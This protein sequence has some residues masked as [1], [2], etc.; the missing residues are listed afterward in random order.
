[1]GPKLTLLTSVLVCRQTGRTWPWRKTQ[2]HDVC[3]TL[4]VKL[5]T[6]QVSETHTRQQQKRNPTGYAKH[7]KS[8]C[9]PVG[10]RFSTCEQAERNPT[11]YAKHKVELHIHGSALCP[12]TH[13]RQQQKRNPTRYAKH[14]K[15]ICIPHR[16]LKHLLLFPGS[17]FCHLRAS[18]ATGC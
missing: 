10:L 17:A 15:S 1:M 16:C 7:K 8:N 12:P 9:I 2:P 13:T 3:K 5:H 14:Q 18:Y 6:P 4:K 11:R